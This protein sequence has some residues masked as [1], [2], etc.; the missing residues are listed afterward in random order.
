[1]NASILFTSFSPFV[2][3]PLE[4]STAKGDSRFLASFTFSMS[5]RWVFYKKKKKMLLTYLALSPLRAWWV[6]RCPLPNSNQ[7]LCPYLQERWVLY[8]SY[9]EVGVQR[10]PLLI[11]I[12]QIQERDNISHSWRWFH[13][14]FELANLAQFDL[15]HCLIV[16]N[17]HEW[18]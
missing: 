8:F 4:T 12:N 6:G 3:T 18:L 11:D 14:G 5:I 2:S 15:V 9:Q 13:S 10:C 16:H 1:M 17:Q 7:I